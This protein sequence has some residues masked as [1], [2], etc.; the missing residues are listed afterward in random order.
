[1]KR[2]RRNK[3]LRHHGR[4]KTRSGHVTRP[5]ANLSDGLEVTLG[6]GKFLMT[7]ILAEGDTMRF[8]Y[9]GYEVVATC[10]RHSDSGKETEKQTAQFISPC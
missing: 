8:R 9:Q 3:K 2:T 10:Q 5:A 6:S 4:Q 1:M 7:Q